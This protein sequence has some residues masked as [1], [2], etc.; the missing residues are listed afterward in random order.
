MAVIEVN[1]LK[2]N[3]GDLEVLK[4]VSLKVEKGDVIAILGPS[5]S[6]K[7]TFLRS[8]INL[9]TATGGDIIIEGDYLCK[10]GVYP[11]AKE[12]RNIIS[13]M[14]MV[15]Q[16]FNL[17]PHMNIISNLTI[18]P[19]LNNQDSKEA[20]YKKADE[21]L[22]KVGLIDKKDVMPSTLS[23]GQKQRVAIAR[24][25]MRD[26]DI[27]LFDEPTSALDPELTGE[28]LN[29]IKDLANEGNTMLIVT[30]EIGFASEVANKILFLE[31]G[32]VGDFGSP[33]DVLLNPKSDRIKAFLNKVDK[34]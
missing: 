23:G 19:L 15:F 10:K 8:L 11:N 7:S 28:V 13:K 33:R 22:N 16:H 2:K 21:I 9:E 30:H 20:I 32:Y 34:K 5:G 29:V 25:L 6:G 12:I 3:F 17:F 26:P 18:S 1:N 31:N 27:I 4:D 14:G 24:A